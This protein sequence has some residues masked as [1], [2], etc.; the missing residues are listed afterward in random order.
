L[1]SAKWILAELI[2]VFHATDI[3]AAT[4]AVEALSTREIPI[5]WEIEGKKRVL[6]PNLT[7]RDR[8]MLLLYSTSG[9]VKEDDLRDWV[10]HERPTDFRKILSSAHDDRLIEYRRTD[11]LIYI[12]PAGIRYVEE[13][14]PLHLS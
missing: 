3:Q 4:E 11:G 6:Q 12:S 1:Q 14:L 7:Y 8:M 13:E 9:A 5:V 2:R 10:E